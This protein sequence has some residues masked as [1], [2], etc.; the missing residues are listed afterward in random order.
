M[1]FFICYLQHRLLC[2]AAC[3]L[4]LPHVQ[5]SFFYMSTSAPWPHPFLAFARR[6]L[7]LFFLLVLVALSF[8]ACSSVLLRS[9]WSSIEPCCTRHNAFFLWLWRSWNTSH[10]AL[11]VRLL[12]LLLPSP[13]WHHGRYLLFIA[14][15]P[16]RERGRWALV[17]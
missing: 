7:E 1:M 10:A 11:F 12:L 5:P 14:P 8:M 4:S 3:T 6:Q 16:M 15:K 13:A 9:P 2:R 17:P